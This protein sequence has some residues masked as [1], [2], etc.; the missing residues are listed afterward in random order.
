MDLPVCPAFAHRHN[1]NGTIDSICKSC[2]ATVATSNWEFDLEQKEIT[3]VCDPVALEKYQQLQV[4]KLPAPFL[5]H[6]KGGG[7]E[8][9]PH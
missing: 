3:H 7:S 8:A 5:I 9:L 2:F 4:E 1:R 6:K